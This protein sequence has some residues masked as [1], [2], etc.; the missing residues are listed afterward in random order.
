MKH[1]VDCMH[2]RYSKSHMVGTAGLKQTTH[3]QMGEAS[4]LTNL[5]RSGEW[6]S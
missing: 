4:W 1:V 2:A 6:G 3:M 5:N